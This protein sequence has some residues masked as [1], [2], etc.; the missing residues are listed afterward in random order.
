M[1]LPFF[2][3]QMRHRITYHTK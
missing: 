2:I 3:K 1:K